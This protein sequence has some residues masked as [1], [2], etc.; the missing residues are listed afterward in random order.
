MMQTV[1]FGACKVRVD[2][3]KTRAWYETQAP[4]NWCDCAG[5]RNMQTVFISSL[6]TEVFAFFDKL[7]IPCRNPL[8]VSHLAGASQ[9]AQHVFSVAAYYLCGEPET[10]DESPLQL[11]DVYSVQFQKTCNWQI[12]DF[13]QPCL[14]LNLM[15]KLPW[16]LNEPNTYYDN[17]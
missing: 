10:F 13:P 11:T 17:R 7:G 2:V 9:D 4:D 8:D 1:T 15:C 6:P 16:L 14:Q 5:C 3:E 12:D